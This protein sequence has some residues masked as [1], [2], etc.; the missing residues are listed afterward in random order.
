MAY[1]AGFEGVQLGDGGGSMHAYPLRD[2]RVQE[3][4]LQAG[5]DYHIPFLRYIYIH[6]DINA[7]T[8]AAW[9]P[10]K[11]RPVWKVLSKA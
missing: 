3:Y 4:Y 11:D 7:I 5:S 2:R 6:W 8:A 1:E 9:T 10:W